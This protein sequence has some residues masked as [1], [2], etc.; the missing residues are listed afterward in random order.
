MS[1]HNLNG[2]F[3]LISSFKCRYISLFWIKFRVKVNEWMFTKRHFHFDF[4]IQFIKK[5]KVDRKIKVFALFIILKQQ[6][7]EKKKKKNETK[8][9]KHWTGADH[10]YFLAE[11]FNDFD[12]FGNR[13]VPFY[14]FSLLSLSLYWL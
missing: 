9:K 4:D 12:R 5:T 10:F 8:L 13:L 2:Q 11:L 3:D 14:S 1:I 6:I 7:S